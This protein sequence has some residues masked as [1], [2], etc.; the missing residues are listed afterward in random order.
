MID[1]ERLISRIKDEERFSPQ[2]YW[3]VSRWSIGYGTYAKGPGLMIS[4]ADADAELRKSVQ[5]ALSFLPRLLPLFDGFD[6]VRAES[7]ADMAY[8][9][10]ETRFK[11]FKKMIRAINRI[12]PDWLEASYQAQESEWYRQ[13]GN[14]SK[15]IVAGLATGVEV[16]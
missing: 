3:D 15:R 10:G 7:I 16:T 9:L 13:V 6:A 11:K 4:M 2:S 1:I 5:V 14:R 8:N 12:P